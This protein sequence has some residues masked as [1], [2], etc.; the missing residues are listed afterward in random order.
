MNATDILASRLVWPA[1]VEEQ[2]GG[3]LVRFRDIPEAI[4]DG[5][6]RAEAVVN[7]ADALAEA[8]AATMLAREDIPAPS[9]RRAGEVMVSPGAVIALK[10]LVYSAMRAEGLTQ[11]ELAER[12]DVDP[13]EVRRMLDPAH[14]GTKVAR[15]GAALAV[16]GIELE[17]A[18][19]RSA[20]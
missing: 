13:R 14:T 8:L 7:A 4:T 16:C 10:A 15:Y 5:V 2:D 18:A 19:H 3:Y 20:A 6:D 9:K 11:A 1:T 12:L 17:I